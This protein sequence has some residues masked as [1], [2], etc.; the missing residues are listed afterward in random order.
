MRAV[1]AEVRVSSA[2]A[3]SRASRLADPTSVW[4]AVQ[5]A[6]ALEAELVVERPP[7]VVLET[8]PAVA[9]TVR[10]SQEIRRPPAASRAERAALA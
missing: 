8:A 10:V 2:P 7:H 4:R 5:V 3:G 9:S 6:A 1:R